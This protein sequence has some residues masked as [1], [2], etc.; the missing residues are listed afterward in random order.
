MA[1]R[2]AT[3]RTAN[4]STTHAAPRPLGDLQTQ[5]APSSRTAS[6]SR[7]PAPTPSTANRTAWPQPAPISPPAEAMPT[8]PTPTRSWDTLPAPLTSCN[9][10]P[11]PTPP[12]PR[13]ARR[14]ALPSSAPPIRRSTTHSSSHSTGPAIPASALAIASY[15]SPPP[16]ARRAFITGFL[17]TVAGKARR[18]WPPLRHP[19]PRPRHLPPHRRLPRAHLHRRCPHALGVVFSQQIDEVS[20]IF[21]YRLQRVNGLGDPRSEWDFVHQ[22]KA[23]RQDDSA[24]IFAIT[25]GQLVH[26]PRR[27]ASQ[28]RHSFRPFRS[29]RV[30]AAFS[31]DCAFPR[32]AGWHR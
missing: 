29:K 8:S 6:H 32:P 16:T 24:G 2:P 7:P 22:S 10:V 25:F 17:T 21:R 12:S 31:P 4:Q 20:F 5:S 14:S 9:D 15:S 28:I 26:T 19:P 11:A 13:T 3:S 1:G 23:L 27:R 30:D 18:P